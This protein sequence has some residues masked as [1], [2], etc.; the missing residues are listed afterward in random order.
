ML[1][2]ARRGAIYLAL[3]SV[4]V[5]QPLLQLYSE[6][7]AVFAAAN[8]EGAIVVWFALFVLLVPPLVLMAIDGMA[9]F[10][11]PQIE[12]HVHHTLVFLGMWATTSVVLRSISF[13]PW[14]IDATFTAI[15]AIALFFVYLRFALVKSWITMLSPVSLLIAGVF[16]ISTQAVIIPP[17]V[18]VLDIKK[19]TSTTMTGPGTPQDKISVLWIVL[20]EAPLFPLLNSQGEVNAKRFPGFAEL[21]NSSTWYRNVLSTSQTTTD[22]VPAMLTGKFPKSGVGPVLANHPKN[23]FT[24]MNGHLSMDAH[25]VVTALCP[26][27]V[28]SR[29]S[30]SGGDHVATP[31][32]NS[33]ATTSTIDEA[34]DIVTTVQRTPFWSF[35]KDATVVVGHKILPKGLR[36]R[37]PAIDEGWG[38]FGNFDN[39]ELSD[40]PSDTTLPV[41]PTTTVPLTEETQELADNITVPEWQIGGPTTQIPL[42][43]D[44]VKRAA[45]SDRSTLHFVHALIPHR[46]WVLAPDLRVS[47]QRLIDDRSTQILDGRRDRLQIHLSQYAAT[48]KVIADMVRSMKRS[49]NWNRTMII[50]TADHG[51]TFQ[52]GER[53]REKVNIASPG[54]LEDL[55]RVPLFIKYPDQVAPTVSDCPVS[56]LDLL[57]TVSAV[58]GIDAGWLTD[59]QNLRGMCPLRESRPITWS[60]GDYVMTSTFADLVRRVQYYDE[61]IDF[62]GNV[63]DI[64]RTGLSGSLVGTP[65]PISTNVESSLTWTLSEPN[66]YQSAGVGRFAP[67]VTRS[68]GTIAASRNFSFTEEALLVIDGKVFG[69]I[70]ELAGLKSGESTEFTSIPMS[71]LHTAGPH[72]IE[73]W[74]VNWANQTAPVFSRVK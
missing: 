24:L 3:L 49:A 65:I 39:N 60:G 55:Y 35:L 74:V 2:L 63:D 53:H 54:T 15:V 41:G 10:L 36:E 62:D 34:D 13:G 6:N 9:L 12:K 25:E 67:V 30:V 4:A 43:E 45:R 26:R 68:R 40:T 71:R 66:T 50:V 29:V 51:I 72:T 59:G 44:V 28:C 47:S 19:T 18:E 37:L 8:Y 64:Y 38:G 61:W 1:V 27:K 20:D 22:A 14:L 46:P 32:E 57:S 16:A 58:T 42:I 73:L 48:D 11:F 7:V 5:A 23:L 31:D 56:H 33:S 21:A 70:S 17:D 69:V 52:P